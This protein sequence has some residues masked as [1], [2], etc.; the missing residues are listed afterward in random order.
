VVKLESERS[1]F[2]ARSGRIPVGTALGVLLLVAAA[3]AKPLRS[4]GF[5]ADLASIAE[6]D[7]HH[8]YAAGKEA[9]E[10]FS[11]GSSSEAGYALYAGNSL[12]QLRSDDRRT[13][14]QVASARAAVDRSQHEGSAI[15]LALNRKLAVLPESE[16]C[17]CAH[18]NGWAVVTAARAQVLK[19]E[20][21][22]SADAIK[23]AADECPCRSA[24][25][26]AVTQVLQE[27]LETL[28]EE[29]GSRTSA[30][31][32]LQRAL[33]SMRLPDAL[34]GELTREL[35]QSLAKVAKKKTGVEAEPMK[36][37]AG[38]KDEAK[39]GPAAKGPADAA[40]PDAINVI[41]NNNMGDSSYNVTFSDVLNQSLPYFYGYKYPP[42]FVKGGQAPFNQPPAPYP[43]EGGEGGDKGMAVVV[44]VNNY[45]LPKYE[46]PWGTPC[47]TAHCFQTR[48]SGVPIVGRLFL[49]DAAASQHSL[50]KP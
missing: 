34:A 9:A 42:A 41:V 40:G 29:L 20:A 17:K 10:L 33:V 46:D 2:M 48:A 45:I 21:G 14:A 5:E 37:P 36:E 22:A 44:N 27:K 4:S 8:G 39:A 18:R 43:W 13:Q 16:E 30:A 38:T 19:E 47:L 15:S 3:G 26:S 49:K 28:T 50:T 7:T 1:G 11:L 6:D 25:V 24:L 12:A 32:A 23:S 35:D 31:L